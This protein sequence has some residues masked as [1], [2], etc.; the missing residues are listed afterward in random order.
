MNMMNEHTDKQPQY[1]IKVADQLNGRWQEWFQAALHGV[2][3]KIN[4]LGLTVIS[5]WLLFFRS[6]N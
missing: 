3:K 5:V 4:N 6:S 2:L 1:E